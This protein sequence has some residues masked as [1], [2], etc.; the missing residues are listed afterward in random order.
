MQVPRPVTH[1]HQ[2]RQQAA[3]AEAHVEVAVAADAP[4]LAAGRRPGRG[5]RIGAGAAVVGAGDLRR[6]EQS[7]R[8]RIWQN[9]PYH[10]TYS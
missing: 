9:I 1:P 10:N 3:A 2:L 8:K 6:H 4:E 5:D 7:S